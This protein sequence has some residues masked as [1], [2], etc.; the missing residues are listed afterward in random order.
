MSEATSEVVIVGGGIIGLTVAW[1]LARAGVGV[2]VLERSEVGDG[3][4]NASAGMLAPLAEA[5]RPGPFLELGIASLSRYADFVQALH[6]ETGANAECCSPGL[7]RVAM[8]EAEE[9]E[10]CT[11]SWQ[12]LAGL[13]VEHLSGDEARRLEPALSPDV[14]AAA[15]SPA[16]KQY[17]PRQLVRML[18]LACAR[19]GVRIVECAPAV[20]FETTKGRVTGVRT[21]T[22]VFPCGAVVI[23]AGA[24]ADQVARWLGARLPVFPVRGQILALRG[25][26][27]PVSYTI[28]AHAG[29]I[30]PRADG[31]VLVG[32]TAE[33]DAGFDARPTAAGLAH[34]MRT[35]ETLV[36]A[37]LPM[38]FE[39]VWSGPRPGCED[40]LPI[41]GLLPGWD[42]VHLAAGHF[43]NGILLA[44]ITGE[45]VAA[46]LTGQP[47]P[48]SLE[49]FR[50]ERFTE[51]R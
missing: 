12:Q 33:Y 13:P 16:E 7:L 48:L 17:D 11:A 20:G 5:N 23:A 19:C 26:P 50:A 31:R 21:A 28:Y 45:I 4:S 42:N 37:L 36:P 46:G 22:E 34:L 43:R 14:I 39:S 1:N 15:L 40:N 25:L 9:A 35:A 24:W 3:A 29:Y 32:A 44:P 51:P 27:S 10:F 49:P 6:E 2:T 38:P 18:A 41:F 8:N 47:P 30:V